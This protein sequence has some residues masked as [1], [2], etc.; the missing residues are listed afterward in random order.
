MH[1]SSQGGFSKLLLLPIICIMMC[2]TL[3]L[4]DEKKKKKN[5]A[6]EKHVVLV[7]QGDKTKPK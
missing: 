4:S 6:W 1:A 5:I 2:K 3:G 7:L